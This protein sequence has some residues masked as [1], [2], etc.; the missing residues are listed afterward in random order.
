MPLSEIEKIENQVAG[1]LDAARIVEGTGGFSSYPTM[2]LQYSVLSWVTDTVAHEWTHTY[3][4]LGRW[5]GTTRAAR[6]C[7][8]STRR[9]PRSSAA[10]SASGCWRSST[11]ELVGPAPWPVPLT[12]RP[13]LAEQHA[14]RAGVR[15]RRVH[16]GDA[17]GRPT[18]CWPTGKMA[19]AEQYM[20]AR[21]QELVKHGVCD[22]QAEPGVLCLSRLLCGRVR[23][24]GPY[25]RKAARAAAA[26]RS[27]PAFRTPCSGSRKARTWIAA[28]RLRARLSA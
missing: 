20:E 8:R 28:L 22:P 4:F 1:D 25:R 13:G 12:M 2:V 27:L 23:R 17:A 9:L 16:A 24:H 19:E 3:L 21:R 14:G 6:R 10:K 15:V 7:G 26:G 5:A 11:P 18:S